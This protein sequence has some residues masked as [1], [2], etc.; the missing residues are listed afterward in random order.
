MLSIKSQTRDE[1]ILA[2]HG[3]HFWL[4]GVVLIALGVWVGGLGGSISTLHC[5]RLTADHLSCSLERGGGFELGGRKTQIDDLRGAKVSEKTNSKGEAIY[6]IELERGQ[7]RPVPLLRK[8]TA[9]QSELEAKAQ[10][11]RLFVRDKGQRE[12]K[13]VQ[14]ERFAEIWRGILLIIG[15]VLIFGIPYFGTIRMSIKEDTIEP[16]LRN[17]YGRAKGPRARLSDVEDIIVDQGMGEG[18]AWCRLVL[19][20]KDGTRIPLSKLRVAE[21]EF[22]EKLAQDLRNFLAKRPAEKVPVEPA[23]PKENAYISDEV[24][25]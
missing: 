9:N 14:N 16:Y 13:V 15:G 19:Q 5:M 23:Q 17:L 4:A 6:R 2:K 12:L 7:G 24:P 20:L 10:E 21:K 22:S 18:N 25:W 1:L 3:N 11:I 8:R